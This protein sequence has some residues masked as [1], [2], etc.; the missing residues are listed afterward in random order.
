VAS[1]GGGETSHIPPTKRKDFLMERNVNHL[2]K[3]KR[4]INVLKMENVQETPERR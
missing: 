1:D 3:N 2:F 4:K